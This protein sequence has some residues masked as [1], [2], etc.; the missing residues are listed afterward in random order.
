MSSRDAGLDPATNLL[1]PPV[2]GEFRGDTGVFEGDDRFE[3]KPIRVRYTWRRVDAD[4]ATWE[5][6]FSPDGGRSWETNWTMALSRER[7]DAVAEILA[8]E[9]ALCQ[10]YLHGDV[11][12]LQRD[13]S[14]D[15]TLINGRGEVGTKAEDLETA[16]TGS[17]RYTRFE[18]RDM[19]VR[20]H[21]D[22][23]AI[24]TGITNVAGVTGGKQVEV[25]VRFTDTFVRENGRWRL[26]AGHVSGIQP[27]R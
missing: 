9:D 5:Q 27:K 18:N 26:A 24:V 15:F 17:I 16:R 3:G 7:H 10:A 2:I 6:A 19:N 13:L 20:L 1:Q 23:A 4:H 11:Q 8:V 21:G 14:D 12:A 22:D 25:E